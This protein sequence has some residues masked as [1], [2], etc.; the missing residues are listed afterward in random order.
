MSGLQMVARASEESGSSFSRDWYPETVGAGIE[1]RKGE[2]VI[3]RL[4][5]TTET[6][7]EITFAANFTHNLRE[8]DG[9]RE[10]EVTRTIHAG[11]R[12][13]VSAEE[14]SIKT[15]QGA[16]DEYNVLSQDAVLLIGDRTIRRAKGVYAAR[17]FMQ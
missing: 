11:V 1:I 2:D 8:A 6:D 17:A 15:I 12:L 5:R 10:G 9:L 16:P 13:V 4:F 3:M 14:R 7:Y